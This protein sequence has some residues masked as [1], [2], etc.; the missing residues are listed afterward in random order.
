MSQP[1][2]GTE[3]E[4]PERMMTTPPLSP[5]YSSDGQ[6]VQVS[7]SSKCGKAQVMYAKP[8]STTN[9][10]TH[11]EEV[12]QCA[13]P[14]K[15]VFKS[16]MDGEDTESEL[17]AIPESDVSDSTLHGSAPV[18][19]PS[20]ISHIQLVPFQDLFDD[21]SEEITS[22][23]QKNQI[24]MKPFK[25]SYIGQ[26]LKKSSTK[27]PT[28]FIGSEEEFLRS[29]EVKKGFLTED[30]RKIS[31]DTAKNCSKITVSS[32]VA[33]LP[34]VAGR[35]T[36]K[37][38]PIGKNKKMIETSTTPVCTPISDCD[39]CLKNNQLLPAPSLERLLPIGSARATGNTNIFIIKHNKMFAQILAYVLRNRLFQK[40]I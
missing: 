23:Q 36:E 6:S 13:Q 21:G 28:W 33:I 35:A 8:S 38:S 24:I 30:N 3:N 17:I 7:L 4:H 12:I 11:W 15:R 1:S 16:N 40:W 27:R 22:S 5:M 31:P 9:M 29:C 32:Q 14:E 25:D 34:V 18:S 26:M 39:D 2:L 20:I 19:V 10:E 37:T